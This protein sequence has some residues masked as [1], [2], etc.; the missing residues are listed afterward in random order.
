MDP[1]FL[2]CWKMPRMVICLRFN[3]QA[4]FIDVSGNLEREELS[5]YYLVSTLLLSVPHPQDVY[6]VP[7][8]APIPPAPSFSMIR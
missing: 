2:R 5:K 6:Y 3:N 1:T 8:F 4:C 7:G